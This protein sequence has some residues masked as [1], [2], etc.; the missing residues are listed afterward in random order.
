MA[1]GL[2]AGQAYVDVVPRVD[3]RAVKRQGLSIGKT[4][5]TGIAAVAAVDFFR[6]SLQAARESRQIAA[7]TASAIKATGGAANL[8][9]EQVAGYA[10][11]LAT[12]TGVDDE[13]IQK[14]ENLL[15]TFRNIR[16]EVGEGNDIFKRATEAGLDLAAQ[17]F[18]SVESNAIQLGKALNDPIKGITAL[19]RAGVTFTQTQR[20]QIKAMVEANDVL[21]AQK[22]ILDEVESQVGGAAE[23]AADPLARLSVVAGNLQED[24]GT[25]LLPSV[26]RLA[27][28]LARVSPEAAGTAVQIGLI[29]AGT[30]GAVIGIRKI[31]DGVSFA[32]DAVKAARGAFDNL[33]LQMVLGKRQGLSYGDMLGSVL[34]PKVLATGAAMGVAG[35]AIADIVRQKQEAQAATEGLIDAMQRE[36]EAAEDT[37]DAWLRDELSRKGM[38]TLAR[39][40]GISTDTLIKAIQGEQSAID[41]VNAAQA[42]F[43]RE[44]GRFSAAMGPAGSKISDLDVGLQDLSV[45][46]SAAEK[47]ARAEADAL[48]TSEAA[49]DVATRTARILA[50][51]I[52]AL[53]GKHKEGSEKVITL[54]EALDR[55]ND[56]FDRYYDKHLSAKDATAAFEGSLDAL[57]ASLKANGD[58]LDLNTE[59]GRAN[60][61]ALTQIVRDANAATEAHYK[62]N[63]SVREANQ[64]AESQRE[65]LREVADRL[66]LTKKQVK[67]YEDAIRNVP[68]SWKT[69]VTADTADASAK[70]A[71]FRDQ[72][73]GIKHG[74]WE[75]VLRTRLAGA[76]EP[77][78]AGGPV[79]PGQ[80]YQVGEKGPELFM[81]STAGT[82]VDA[83]TTARMSG[84][85][86]INGDIN[87]SSSDRPSGETLVSALRREAFLAGW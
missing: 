21:S 57:R 66:G 34:T 5:A 29:G 65:R 80:M 38:V 75:A 7:V 6:D 9:S 17:G 56:R 47:G 60:H 43:A 4:I 49:G 33:R 71:A 19:Q 59:K 73:E 84:G 63:H 11:E 68:R 53:N 10:E 35:L 28:A 82:V 50:G 1:G 18:G 42:S 64:L 76:P 36:R 41:A 83:N 48:Y 13:V 24:I 14:G 52:D 26:D 22:I 78:A 46:Y 45:A 72:L 79:R 32:G 25:A 67:D 87:I 85:V 58:T 12:L 81:P 51:E 69:K 86:T 55:L 23:A 44:S 31:A 2:S 20:D 16:D 37:T 40:Q 30:V 3:S 77:R 27:D 8:S 15:L 74:S 39:E 54:T 62:Q 61:G 70:V